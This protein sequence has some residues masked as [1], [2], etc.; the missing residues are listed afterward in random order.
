MSN[1]DM[2]E[3]KREANLSIYIADLSLI[4]HSSSRWPSLKARCIYLRYNI[5]WHDTVK[6]ADPVSNTWLKWLFPIAFSEL[7][8]ENWQS[9]GWDAEM[10]GSLFF[11]HQSLAERSRDD[12]RQRPLTAD[13]RAEPAPG[14]RATPMSV[15]LRL[16]HA[17]R[18]GDRQLPS[19][20]S[21]T[22]SATLLSSRSGGERK[23]RPWHARFLLFRHSPYH[24]HP[25]LAS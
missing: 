12:V 11:S 10:D 25:G 24:Q 6:K 7:A 23:R 19:C 15:R 13:R 14:R 21:S 16:C 2:P 5:P 9:R 20:T 3:R 17:V 22:R 8:R 18:H 1:R 4:A